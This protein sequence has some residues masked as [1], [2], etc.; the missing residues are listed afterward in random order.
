MPPSNTDQKSTPVDS[1]TPPVP[2][3]DINAP[4]K[5]DTLKSP[6]V[7]NIKLDASLKF[8]TS[9]SPA[10]GRSALSGIDKV[11]LI[12]GFLVTILVLTLVLLAFLLV[13]KF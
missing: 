2:V 11:L 7:P 1:Q 6:P 5:V 12:F 9:V 4:L 3:I 10:K 8:E 13:S